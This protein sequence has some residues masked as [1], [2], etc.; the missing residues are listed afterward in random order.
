MACSPALAFLF[1]TQH[2]TKT[3]SICDAG[4]GTHGLMCARQV[5]YC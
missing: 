4:A 2:R 1:I 5:L 3:S